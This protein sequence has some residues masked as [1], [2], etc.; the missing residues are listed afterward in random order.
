MR[1]AGDRFKGQPKRQ[2]RQL[3]L[4]GTLSFAPA[5][6][7]EAIR[8]VKSSTAIGP[9]GMSAFHL[10]MLAHGAINY[11]TTIFNLSISTG[12]DKHT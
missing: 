4:R 1:L 5:D 2:F 7:K 12:P 10:N 11:L 8:L 3:P 9:D 6:T